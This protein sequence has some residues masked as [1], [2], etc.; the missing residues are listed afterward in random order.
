MKQLDCILR[1]SNKF[2]RLP[3]VGAKTA[4]RYAYSVIDMTPEE[5]EEFCA[6]LR[7][8]KT[9]VRYC[10]EC[11]NFTDKETCEICARREK[12]VICVVAYPKDVLALERVSGYKGVYHVLHGTLSPLEGRG[13]DSLRIKELLARLNGVE[14]VILA[15]STDVEG[16]ATAMYLAR[17]LKP[18]GVKVSR[19]AQ[20]ISM[21]SELEYADEIT[22]LK[23]LEARTEL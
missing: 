9:Q 18:M 2:A 23:A 12:N 10:D 16:E 5:V 7:D 19:I 13:P 14:E 17:L 4:Q 20:G 3:G 6:A 11:G 21:G 22:L 8:V 15:T 1:L